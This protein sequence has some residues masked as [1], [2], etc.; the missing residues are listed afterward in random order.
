M[1][2]GIFKVDR[3]NTL[4]VQDGASFQ[5]EWDDR[6]LKIDVLNLKDLEKRLSEL[7]ASPESVEPH[8]NIRLLF[9]RAESALSSSDYSQLI[10]NCASIFETLAKDILADPNVDPHTLGSF[11]EK[12]R[13]TS[14]LPDPVLDFI[15]DQY[16][17]R[18]RVPLAGHGSRLPSP[19]M[20]NEQATML[21]EMTRAFV[22]TEYRLLT[23][24]L[25][26]K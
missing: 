14:A 26:R 6:K 8:A 3:L 7:D 12:Y 11:F 19:A 24:K 18:N 21:V 13:K 10:H 4:L 22:K 17:L 9:N 16:K 2:E 23:S 25:P 20:T 5:F 15:L 1:H